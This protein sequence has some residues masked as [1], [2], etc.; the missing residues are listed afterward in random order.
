MLDDEPLIAS[1]L[2]AS[3]FRERKN[4]DGSVQPGGWLSDSGVLLDLLVPEALAGRGRRSADLGAHGN[5][6]ARRAVGLE[7]CW[8]DNSS[9]S[10]EALDLTDRRAV[11]MK[12]AGPGAL[13]VAKLHK[14]GERVAHD[15]RVKDTDALDI[16]RILRAIPTVDLAARMSALLASEHAGTV[17]DN[18]LRLLGEL[19]GSPRSDGIVLAQRASA[20]LLDPDEL[21]ESAV[22]LS[23]DMLRS[24]RNDR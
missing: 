7:G 22:M 24:I 10:I 1:L 19:F 3:G 16:F 2:L 21:A 20:L 6:A 17:T 13:L 4:D 15:D 8:V 12:V 18:G 23:N 11:T 5:R 14:L 9:M